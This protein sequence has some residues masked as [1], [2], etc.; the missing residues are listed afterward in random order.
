M[1]DLTLRQREVL[2]Y[3]A[4]RIQRGSVPSLR[5]IG[6]RL[7]IASTN[8]V[9]DHLRALEKKGLVIRDGAKSRALSITEAGYAAIGVALCPRCQGSGR[10]A[11]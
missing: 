1:R 8:G 3:V 10:A 9:N 6:A 5:E 11:P 7:G 4:S 2:V